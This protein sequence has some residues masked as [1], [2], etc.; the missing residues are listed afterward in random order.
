MYFFVLKLS[1]LFSEINDTNITVIKFQTDGCEGQ[2]NEIN[3]L[4][5]IQLILDV[6]YPIRGHLSISVISPKGMISRL[7][8]PCAF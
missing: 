8:F 7:I 4:E 5:H 2:R 3:F 6:Y 1:F